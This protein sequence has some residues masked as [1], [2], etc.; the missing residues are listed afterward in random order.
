MNRPLSISNDDNHQV[1]KFCYETFEETLPRF[2]T[3]IEEGV[4]DDCQPFFDQNLITEYSN[5]KKVTP[6]ENE[7]QKNI[8]T[9][10]NAKNIEK[11]N[12][13][14]NSKI[15]LNCLKK[16][17]KNDKRLICCKNKNARRV[18]QNFL[19]IYIENQ[20]DLFIDLNQKLKV[21]KLYKII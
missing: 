7:V 6:E 9:K 5:I 12:N 1:C 2:G 10:N 16:I 13:Q 21:K 8:D 15:C 18:P 17:N 3:K 11:N 4:C 14:L 20:K 19:K